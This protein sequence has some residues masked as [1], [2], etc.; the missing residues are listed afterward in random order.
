MR[1]ARTR[2]TCPL[3]RGQR[4]CFRRRV[5]ATGVD[6]F[7]LRTRELLH[8][9]VEVGGVDGAI[10]ASGHT[11]HGVELPVREAEAAPLREERAGVRELLDAVDVGHEHVPVRVHRDTLVV[12]ELSIAEPETA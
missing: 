12:A 1:R 6:P 5:M 8:P 9:M 2:Y 3:G 4:R 10:G 7:S 11:E